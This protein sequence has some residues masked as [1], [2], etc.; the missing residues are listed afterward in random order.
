MCQ[1][2]GEHSS[3]A[4]STANGTVPPGS[5]RSRRRPHQTNVPTSTAT[6]ATKPITDGSPKRT[7]RPGSEALSTVSG[8]GSEKAIFSHSIPLDGPAANIPNSVAPAAEASPARSGTQR[9]CTAGRSSNGPSD[10]FSAT[11]I[12]YST[13][14]STGRPRR[15]AIQPA[16]RPTSNTG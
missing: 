14:A 15:S 16:T 9:R 7:A 11:V 3:P 8:T 5:M 10:G 6:P 13:A 2:I 1:E 4:A 12:P